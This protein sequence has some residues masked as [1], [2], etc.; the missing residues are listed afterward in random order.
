[1]IAKTTEEMKHLKSNLSTRFKMKDMGKLH[2]CLGIMIEKDQEGKSLWIHQQPYISK[3]I[4]KIW[5]IRCKTCF[6]SS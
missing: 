6:N 2:Y 5:S 4:K 3:L 1:M